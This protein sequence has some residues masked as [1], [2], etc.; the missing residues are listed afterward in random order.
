[1]CG[2]KPISWYPHT[3]DVVIK[4]AEIQLPFSRWHAI[5]STKFSPRSDTRLFAALL[6]SPNKKL[7]MRILV[8]ARTSFHLRRI[9]FPL[10]PEAVVVGGPEIPNNFLQLLRR[11]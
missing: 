5:E 1:L 10:A 9:V 2:I 8:T 3:C 11:R 4:C 6:E 7:A